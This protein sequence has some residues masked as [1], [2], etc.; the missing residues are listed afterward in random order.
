MRTLV[1]SKVVARN[2][3]ISNHLAIKYTDFPNSFLNYLLSSLN[4]NHQYCI[5]RHEESYYFY[6]I[7]YKNDIDTCF[8]NYLISLLK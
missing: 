8:D 1:I 6:P 3:S 4:K 7:M 2:S 5:T